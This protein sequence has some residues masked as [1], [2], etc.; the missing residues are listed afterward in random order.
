MFRKKCLEDIRT[1]DKSIRGR[2][3]RVANTA[4]GYTLGGSVILTLIRG[5]LGNPRGLI[6]YPILGAATG[7]VYEAIL[8]TGELQHSPM[9]FATSSVLAVTPSM[10]LLKQP[11][12]NAVTMAISWSG[13]CFLFQVCQELWQL[14]TL[15][16]RFYN[17]YDANVNPSRLQQSDRILYELYVKDYQRQESTAAGTK[18]VHID[19]FRDEDGNVDYRAYNQQHRIYLLRGRDSLSVYISEIL[20]SISGTVSYLHNEMTENPIEYYSDSTPREHLPPSTIKRAD[21]IAEKYRT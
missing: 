4:I 18:R 8:E 15:S 6:H 2:I 12:L 3:K 1:P 9:L 14:S 21:S 20:S 11:L 13:L 19:D 7:I 5:R 16:K 17:M 10:M